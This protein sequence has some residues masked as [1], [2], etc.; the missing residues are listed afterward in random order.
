MIRFSLCLVAKAWLLMA[1]CSP[2]SAGEG[3]AGE[4]KVLFEKGV[5][6]Y[7]AKR[8]EE[9]LEAF[10]RVNAMR[11]SWKLFYNIGQ[12]RAVLKQYG[13][14][15]D[16][17]ERYLAQGG[18]EVTS[19]RKD[20]ILEE[21]RRLKELVGNLEVEAPEGATVFVDGEDRGKAPLPGKI[22]LAVG[23]N[24]EVVVKMDGEV[25]LEREVRVGGGESVVVEVSSEVEK[26]VEEPEGEA[27]DGEEPSKVLPVLSGVSAG[28]AVVAG[29]LAT[30]FWVA[31]GKRDDVF[32][33]RNEMLANGEIG[34]DDDIDVIGAAINDNEVAWWENTDGDGSAWTKH[35]VNATFA[36][37]FAVNAADMDGDG[38]IDVLGASMNDNTVAWWENTAGDG[39]AW[40]EHLVDGAFGG[41][42]DVF[43]EDVDGDGDIDVVGA[44]YV[45]DLVSWWEN[46]DGDG[47]AWTEHTVDSLFDAA[48]SVHPIDVDGDGDM[49]IFGAARQGGEIAWW[50]SDCIP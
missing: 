33:E 44:A 41:A 2:A 8:Y 34:A 37:A 32:Q 24:H 47:S 31:A 45:D 40:T 49:D 4:A 35:A 38:D 30:G 22:R 36:S 50:E 42:Q 10:E 7:E 43:G 9:A 16:A 11:P 6:H 28:L 19:S 27:I 14:A 20:E 15:I 26:V 12:C 18:D 17:F 48:C 25:L 3:D 39:S 23:V 29:G 21:L 46:I 1:F 5:E 13:R